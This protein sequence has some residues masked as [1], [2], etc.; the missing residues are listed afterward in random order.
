MQERVGSFSPMGCDLD[1]CRESAVSLID[2]A[3]EYARPRPC[4]RR[5]QS[6]RAK[7]RQ[8]APPPLRFGLGCALGDRFIEKLLHLPRS[9]LGQFALLAAQ[10]ALLFA[11]FSLLFSQG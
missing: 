10:F 2:R 5:A 7:L 4:R 8:G 6:T 11:K 3:F 9:L 1:Q